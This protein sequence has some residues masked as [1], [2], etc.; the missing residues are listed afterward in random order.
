[1]IRPERAPVAVP[2]NHAPAEQVA[3]L[4]AEAERRETPC[5]DGRMVWRLWGDGPP[6][7]LLHGGSGS[8]THWF[9]NIRTLSK[10][11]RLHV[12]DMPGLGSSDM[13][14]RAFM[15]DD[16][17]ATMTMVAAVIADGIRE[18]LGETTPYQL[19]G[20]SLGSIVATYL[21]A[22]EGARVAS[23]TLIGSA[24]FGLPW[25]GLRGSLTPMARDMS[26]QQKLEVQRKN[27]GIIMVGDPANADDLA[28]YLQLGNVTRA[29]VRTH[30]IADTDSLTRALARVTSP[31]NGI[32]GRD[33]VYAQPNLKTIEGI[34]RGHDPDAGFT[35][36]D[37]AG[38]WVM[39]ECAE[40][41]DAALIDG[42]RARSADL[43]Q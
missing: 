34:L 29:R 26:E 10:H 28:A 20:F 12:A 5:G 4:A 8:W 37:D 36:I 6:L 43:D 18:L 32:W 7:V 25:D 13:P 42:I 39:Y 11:F 41:F 14:P 31:I 17:P 9:R 3:R 24:A 22:A 33:D 23:L 30:G 38:H 16:Y 35:L 40:A 27:L 15:H 19:A 21:A 1:M 2:T